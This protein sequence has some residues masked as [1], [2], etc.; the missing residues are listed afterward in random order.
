MDAVQVEAMLAECRL[1]KDASRA[2]FRHLRQFLGKSFFESEH[3]RREAF[4]GKDFPPIV[5]RLELSDKTQVDFWYK[6]P[7]KLIQHQSNTMIHQAE[8]DGLI[9]L[10]ICVGGDH[11]G[12]KFRM[13]LK[14]LFCFEA[15]NTI[16]RLY[17]I[18]SVS[19]PKDNSQ[20]LNE[21][22]LQPIGESLQAI[23]DGGSYIVQHDKDSN[24]LIVNYNLMVT[25]F[26]CFV[27]AAVLHK[28]NLIFFK[29]FVVLP[30]FLS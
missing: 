2:L 26:L 4:A 30:L 1:G 5:K 23:N 21:T 14:L 28:F 15:K 16:S 8:L 19:H 12:G 22:V 29:S 20:L 3:K 18:A 10:D 9:R 6:L 17:Q 13:S 25:I 11:G 27:F 24:K 7:H